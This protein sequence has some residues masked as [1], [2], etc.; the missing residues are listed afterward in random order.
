MPPLHGAIN[1]HSSEIV[2]MVCSKSVSFDPKVRVT[3]TLSYRDY[4]IQEKRATF[5]SN[6]EQE[7]IRIKLKHELVSALGGNPPTDFEL[8]GLEPFHPEASAL[9]QIRRALAFDEVML[10]QQQQWEEHIYDANTIAHVYK[11]ATQDSV[12]EAQC[13]ALSYLVL[14]MGEE[15]TTLVHPAN[16]LS[17][18]RTLKFRAERSRSATLRQRPPS[19]S[20][21]A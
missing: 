21:A 15:S 4:T 3:R 7:S 17:D 2:K 5:Y 14:D 12:A 13:R 20:A 1:A 19:T 16:K 6:L 18:T 10:E 9:R 11:L 8:R